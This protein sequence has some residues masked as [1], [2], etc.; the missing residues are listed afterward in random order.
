S[1]LDVPFTAAI[2]PRPL[3]F[4]AKKELF[5]HWFWRRVF[6]R[7]GAVPVDREG[8]DRAAL[9]KLGTSFEDGGAPGGGFPARTRP[10]APEVGP[11][12]P[13]AA[14]VALRTG[15]TLVPVGISGSEQPVVRRRAYPSF[16]RVCVVV[17][18]PIAPPVSSGPVKRSSI[19]AITTLLHAR[20]QTCFD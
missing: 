11:L 1:V 20:L 8:T 10:A 3:R 15:S 7:L 14:Y 9:R 2:T 5:E 18:D 17:G 19:D 13:G 12:E 4:M 16:A 6:I